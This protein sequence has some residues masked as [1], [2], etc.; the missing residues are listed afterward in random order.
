MSTPPSTIGYTFSQYID[1]PEYNQPWL[2]DSLLP[3]EGQGILGGPPKSRKSYLALQMALDMAH[4]RPFLGF[5]TVACKI[6]YIQLDTP[7]SLWKLRLKR[8]RKRGVAMTPEAEANLIFLDRKDTPFPFDIRQPACAAWL[9]ARITEH[10]P[11]FVILD[12]MSKAHGANENDR[13]EME[14]VMN[15]FQSA[16]APSAFLLVTHTKKE[17]KDKGGRRIESSIIDDIRGSSA[18]TGGVD[19]IMGMRP[20]KAGTKLE[21]KG[22]ETEDGLLTLTSLPTMFFDTPPEVHWNRLIQAILMEDYPSNRAAAKVLHSRA[23]AIG[24]DRTEDAC[25]KALERVE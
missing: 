18:L 2:I 4:G 8:L 11:D 22:R 23:V 3:I 14:P 20:T 13:N 7:R 10:R 19:L 25:R 16:I 6:C 21:Y 15:A 24:I 1:L 5:E 12:T 9:R 17:Q